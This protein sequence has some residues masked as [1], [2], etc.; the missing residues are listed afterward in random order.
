M[1]DHF[2][3]LG[4]LRRSQP[5]LRLGDIQF[6]QAGEGRVGFTRSYEGH[7]VGIYCNAGNS[8]WEITPT[9]L[10]L[11][12]KLELSAPDRLVLSPGGFCITED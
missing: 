7:T 5:A 1:I 8:C 3:R 6:F 2:A 9:K 12:C 11:G 10:L 4:Q